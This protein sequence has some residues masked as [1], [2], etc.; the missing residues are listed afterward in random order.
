MVSTVMAKMTCF[1]VMSLFTTKTSLFFSTVST[2]YP[3]TMFGSFSFSANCSQSMNI[4]GND[5]LSRSSMS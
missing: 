4:L 3:V 5:A 1:A 2:V